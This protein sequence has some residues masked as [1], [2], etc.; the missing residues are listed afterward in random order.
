MLGILILVGIVVGFY[1]SAVKR[2]LNGY[3]YGILSIVIWFAAQFL[4]ALLVVLMNPYSSEGELIGYGLAGSVAGIIG[5][6][7]IMD[8]AGKKKT[9]VT[10][11]Y[12]EE[13][14]D[15]ESTFR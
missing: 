14:M 5:L 7:F 3:L 8:R 12:S 9:L 10:N 13:V 15:D 1:K 2:Q 6:Y 11:K 4:V